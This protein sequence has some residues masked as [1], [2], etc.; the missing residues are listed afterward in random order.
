MCVVHETSLYNSEAGRKDGTYRHRF[1][2][3]D[4]NW[5][6]VK[7]SP[8]FSFM[9]GKIEFCCGLT[10]YKN[11]FLLT[12]GFQDNAAYILKVSQDVVKNFIFN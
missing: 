12:F 3:W 1:I 9:E 6:I 7:I 4:K 11:D 2:V 8:L 10:P 5:N